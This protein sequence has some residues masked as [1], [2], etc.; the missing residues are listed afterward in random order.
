MRFGGGSAGD[1]N[2]VLPQGFGCYLRVKGRG[3]DV[4]GTRLGRGG[5]LPAR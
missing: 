2:K 5:Y 4:E 3:E 1:G